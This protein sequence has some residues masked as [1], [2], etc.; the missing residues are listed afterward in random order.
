M[1]MIDLFFNL[2]LYYHKFIINRC[3]K[4]KFKNN[5]K[6]SKYFTTK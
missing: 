2:F 5:T 6:S 1:S 3:I 4:Y